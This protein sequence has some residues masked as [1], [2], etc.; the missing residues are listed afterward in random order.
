M[1]TV[2]VAGAGAIGGIVAARMAM[3]GH[4]VGVIA[5]G[6]HL[7]A[8]ERDGLVLDDRLAGRRDAVRV[9]ASERAD[10]FAPPDLLVIGVKAPA[11]AGLLP[12]LA[13]LVTPRTIVVPALNGLPWWYF[14]RAGGRFDGRRIACLDPDGTLAGS[15]DSARIVG[16]VVLLA[17]EVAAPGIVSHT[18][19]RTMIIGEPDAFAACTSAEATSRT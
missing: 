12:T 19:H 8:I 3:A 14:H 7:R 11:L 1:A 4:D 15:I 18:A 13:P 6:P 9:R 2:V 5:R 10:A 16:C 17:G